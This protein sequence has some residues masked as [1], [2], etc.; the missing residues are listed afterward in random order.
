M[1]NQQKHVLNP[2]KWID[3]Y[4]DYLFNYTISRLNDHDLAKDLVQETFLSALKS[5]KNF[6]GQATEK[7]WLVSILKR[8]IIDQYRKSNSKKGQA[9]IRMSFYETGENKGKWIEEKAPS[10]WGNFGEKDIENE[11]L[12][13]ILNQCI[14]GLPEKQRMVFLLKT[15]KNYK[16]EE[17]SNELQLSASNIWVIIHRARL[18][19]REC[20]ENNWFKN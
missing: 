8:K 20:M 11:E 3:N 6:K 19:L 18:K 5:M 13:K 16:T 15:V 1:T 14:N 10:H 12:K 2:K 4:A 9:E 17:I 7:T